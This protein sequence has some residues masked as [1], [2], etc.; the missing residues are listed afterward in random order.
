GSLEKLYI[1]E[2]QIKEN[3]IS[4][5]KAFLNDLDNEKDGW[6]IRLAKDISSHNVLDTENISEFIT[7]A[8][9]LILDRLV[10]LRVLSD[11]EIE[12]D[13]LQKMEAKLEGIGDVF[14]IYEEFKDSFESLNETYN[15]SIF[16]ERPELDKVNVSKKVFLSIVKELQAE[17][18]RYN[19]KVIPVEILGTIY[20]QYLGKVVVLTEKRARI[21]YK[22]EVRKAGGVYYTPEYIVRYIVENTLGEKLK[23]CKKIE[24][25][26][27]LKICDPAC[28]SG[29]F[30]LG[31]YDY[32]IK[33]VISYY[34]KKVKNGK[35]GSE[36]K[37]LSKEER[38]LVYLDR[39]GRLR[40]TSK[41]KRE[42]LQSCIY[43]VDIDPQ[44]VE[45]TKLSLSLK[46]LEDITHDEVYTER[47]L[48][49]TTILP[50]LEGNIK[51]GNSL[52]P[53][54]NGNI[55][56]LIHNLKREE[57]HIL[58]PFDWNR[59][60][61][62]IMQNGGFDCVIGNPPYLN[63]D[64]VW[65][66]K[67][68]R[69]GIIKEVY[70]EIHND[71]T[72]ILFYFIA[73]A[74]QLTKDKVGFIV[75][76]AFLEAYKANKLREYIAKNIKIEQIIDFRNFYVFKGVG[77]TTCILLLSKQNS[78]SQFKVYKMTSKELKEKELLDNLKNAKLFEYFE[79]QRE[80]LN[81]SLWSLEHPTLFQ[82]N[83]KIDSKGDLLGNI[84]FIGKGMET[85]RNEIFGKRTLE[86]IQSFGLQKGQYFKRAAN[87]D[88][89]RYFLKDRG[90]YLI[91]IEDFEKFKDLPENLQIYL[92]QNSKEL[93]SRAAYQRGDC[94]W[95]KYTW[96]LHKQWYGKQKIISP[97]MSQRNRFMID[98]KNEY[99]SLTDTTVLFENEQ[100][101]DFKYILALLNSK[102]L[103]F[104]FRRIGKLKSGGI[105]EYV[106]NSVSK[107]PIK[108]IDFQNKK[109]KEIH[110]KLV[111]Y[112]DSLISF[113]K[114]LD[115]EISSLRKA[116]LERQVQAIDEEVDQLV[117]SLYEL[118][119][120]EIKIVE[121]E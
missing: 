81:P 112:V 13:V 70:K 61:K 25:L 77:I 117:Y 56:E 120:E 69:L 7:S 109:E 76:R 14:N 44:A 107:L 55:F 51:C 58:K 84:L 83:Q 8:V 26:F 22:A 9:Q 33:W 57:L 78:S 27:E 89:Q 20:E 108:R 19:F 63:I 38:K 37:G 28:G 100:A 5:D 52:V 95:W 97:F 118:T 80:R 94:E 64:D 41:L 91:Y 36:L 15:G 59:E 35:N 47:S 85:G 34:E 10:F 79:I 98:E 60:F 17:N 86:E 11:R 96:P 2:K 4:P 72:D 48:F 71:K 73:R 23:E 46:A 62:S 87:S 116:Q 6:R 93:K 67:D 50:P 99:L 32:L 105:Y 1:N 104:R 88:I 66:K 113:K 75:S 119:P 68:F 74:I 39:D 110:D 111:K 43:G 21:E 24:D 18:S 49:H 45:V 101:E 106:D 114:E 40:L 30:L 3:R 31:A 53:T 103:T 90:E 42:I 115:K 102:L 121:A 92:K 65:G 54:R 82:L 29:S 16:T 12:E